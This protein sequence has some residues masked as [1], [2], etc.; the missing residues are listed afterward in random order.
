MSDVDRLGRSS[1]APRQER[2]FR[3]SGAAHSARLRLEQK[4][5]DSVWGAI[6]NPAASESL[7][8]KHRRRPTMRNLIRV[9]VVAEILAAMLPGS[10]R[11]SEN[12]IKFFERNSD[13]L[14]TQGE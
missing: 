1:P 10:A 2:G 7:V 3:R 11:A 14:V 13:R 6:Y 4:L 9:T 8:V 5:L 12:I